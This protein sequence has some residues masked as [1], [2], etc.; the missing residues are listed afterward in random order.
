VTDG[1]RTWRI[2]SCPWLPRELS[3]EPRYRVIVDNDFAGD[4][5]DLF[6]LAHH[7]LS[8]SVEV[9]VVISSR[10]SVG[11][12]SA[13]NPGSAAL[14][15]TRVRELFAV[16]SLDAEQ[17]I[18][19]GS[20]DPL[21]N[22]TEPIQ[23]PGA[24]AIVA[25]AMRDVDTPLFFAGGGSLTE[26]ASAYLIEPRIADRLTAVWIG[27]PEYP[28]LAFPP[29]SGEPEFNL[30]L[31][32]IAAQVVFNDS[33]LTIWQV[34]RN[35]YGQCLISD[36]ELY[37]RVRPAGALGTHLWDEALRFKRQLN[38]LGA[39]RSETYALGDSPLV[40]LTALQSM[41][42]PDT[43][44]SEHQL[45]PAPTFSSE[46]QMLQSSGHRRLIRVYTRVDTRLMIEDMI[47]KFNSLARWQIGN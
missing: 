36:I 18:T 26:L 43:S 11:G 22:R 21:T 5:D 39:D 27:G 37:D 1:V 16:M 41:F 8:P 3:R 2:G 12:P 14:G 28:G 19:E 38:F 17:L 13:T 34:P 33:A 44:S 7:L 15:C 23:S 32:P 31:D 24:L 25:E 42:A 46:A 45:L 40:L 9:R 47:G 4:P 30:N 35:V 6:Q 10:F 29:S 20:D